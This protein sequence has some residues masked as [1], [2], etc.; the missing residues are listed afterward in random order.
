M[1]THLSILAWEITW[2]EE[3]G[4]LRSMGSQRVGHNWTTCHHWDFSGLLACI[5]TEVLYIL[6][7]LF[8]IHFFHSLTASRSCQVETGWGLV[9]G[10]VGLRR[11]WLEMEMKIVYKSC[12]NRRQVNGHLGHPNIRVGRKETL[13]M[14]SCATCYGG[15]SDWTLWR[16]INCLPDI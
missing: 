13:R 5:E 4:M 2:T 6:Q 16:G 15:V 7:L 1:A 11:D 12:I 9:K 10:W 8:L 3:P 14:T